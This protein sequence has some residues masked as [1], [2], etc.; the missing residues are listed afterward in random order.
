MK[1]FPEHLKIARSTETL[2]TEEASPEVFIHGVEEDIKEEM[3]RILK[4]E[5]PIGEGKAGQVFELKNLKRTHRD[6][7]IKVFRPELQEIK[8]RS[9]VEYRSLQ[10]MEPEEEF[11]LQ[12]D[13]YMEGFTELPR[14]IAYTHVGKWHIMAM[15][16]I[17][18]YTLAEIKEKGAQISGATWDDLYRLMFKLNIDHRVVHRDLHPGNI[19][20]E[21]DEELKENGAI[22]GRLRIID[23]GLARRIHGRPERDDY[24]LT[25]GRDV[26]KFPED[27][28]LIDQLKPSPAK[29]KSNVFVR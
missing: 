9:M 16:R 27:K 21:T 28:A 19:F 23:L 1:S 17:K 20:L 25:I 10:A 26:L 6:L 4:N 12:D 5:A 22:S 29:G 7:C 18:G 24:T 11:T 8:E 2:E 14:P 3:E 15:E 13:L